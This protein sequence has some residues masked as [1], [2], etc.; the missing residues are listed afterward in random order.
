MTVPPFSVHSSADPDRIQPWPLQEFWPAQALSA[1]LHFDVPLQELMP[2]H[3]TEA[4]P[5]VSPADAGII[6][7]LENK[8]A[9]EVASANLAIEF[10][11][12]LQR[13]W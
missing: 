6:T 3:F 11:I 12:N 2:W 9:A 8:A 7:A 5:F 4:A 10:M 1:V 13:L